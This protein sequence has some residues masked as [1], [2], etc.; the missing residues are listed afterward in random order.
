MNIAAL[1]CTFVAAAHGF[2][3]ATPPHRYSRVT[4]AGASPA[5]RGWVRSRERSQLSSTI[6]GSG[7]DSNATRS[8]DAKKSRAAQSSSL[9]ERTLAATSVVEVPSP[10]VKVSSGRKGGYRAYLSSGFYSGTSALWN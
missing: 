9:A 6:V 1:L 7:L 5:G 2:G 4:R 8:F 10:G 3:P